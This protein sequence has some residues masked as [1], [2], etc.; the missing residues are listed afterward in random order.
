M[1][2]ARL[3]IN[4]YFKIQFFGY[5]YENIL[6]NRYFNRYFLSYHSLTFFLLLGL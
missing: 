4:S 2:K 3:L 6:V 1:E 5:G